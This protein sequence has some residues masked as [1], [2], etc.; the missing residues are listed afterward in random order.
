MDA[1][2]AAVLVAAGTASAE[3]V[4]LLTRLLDGLDD[5]LIGAGFA[6]NTRYEGV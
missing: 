3:M 4:V 6:V 2:I 1:D 5:L